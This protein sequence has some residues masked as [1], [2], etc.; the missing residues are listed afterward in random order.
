M[1]MKKVLFGFAGRLRPRRQVLLRRRLLEL[2]TLGPMPP[3]EVEFTD[4]NAPRKPNPGPGPAELR[5]VE[6]AM[7]LNES[8]ISPEMKRSQAA[9]SSA[10]QE[11]EMG[12][13]IFLY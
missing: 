3:F 9:K 13:A 7:S 8:W 4:G 11:R 6:D 12:P 2:E 5:N 1:Y 10:G